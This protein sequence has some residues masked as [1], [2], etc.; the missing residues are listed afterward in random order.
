MQSTDA[1]LFVELQNNIRLKSSAA[2]RR[3]HL[4]AGFGIL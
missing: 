4:T 2:K 1:V 3:W